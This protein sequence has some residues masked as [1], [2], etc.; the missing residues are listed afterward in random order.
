MIARSSESLRQTARLVEQR[1]GGDAGSNAVT[2]FCHEMDLS[3]LDAL[4]DQFQNILESYSGAQYDSCWLIN[5][6]GSLGPLGVASSMSGESTMN[7]L[8]RAVDLNVTSGIWVSSQFAKTFLTSPPSSTTETKTP[9]VRIVN[10]SSLCAIEPFPTMS[11][12]CAGK[13]GRDMFHACLA[14]EHSPSKKND[15]DALAKTHDQSTTQPKQTLKVL[16]YAPGACDTQMTDDLATCSVLDSGL[17]EYFS[18]S[19]QESKLV[20]PEDTAKKLV[21]KLMLDEF[22]SG[23]HVDYWDV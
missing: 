23:S 14:K 17:H 10:I 20:R 16:N 15:E 11:I 18:T 21:Q 3:D 4:P 9:V 2:T 19:K 13:A 8:R 12:Y 5:N 7:E 1:S 22:E 6:A